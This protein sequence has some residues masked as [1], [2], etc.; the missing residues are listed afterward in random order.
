MKTKDKY[1]MS[2]SRTVEFQKP[3]ACPPAAVRKEPHVLVLVGI[4]ELRRSARQLVSQLRRGHNSEFPGYLSA[5][6]KDAVGVNES[7]MIQDNA[8]RSHARPPKSATTLR[9][10]TY[11]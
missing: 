2:L 4:E 9:H 11:G 3:T 6:G 5:V 1:K 8:D 10:A 7:G